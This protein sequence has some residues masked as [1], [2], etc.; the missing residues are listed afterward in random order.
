MTESA[1]MVPK[2]YSAL[3]ILQSELCR[4]GVEKKGYNDKQ[5]FYFRKWDD[6]QQALAP[7]LV[8]SKVLLIPDVVSREVTVG[9][10][11]SGSDY[12]RVMLTGNIRF[13]SVED[14]S[15][16]SFRAV[17]EAADTGDK[18]TSKALT[19]MVKYAVIHG[20]Q[21]PLEGVEDG[22]ESTSVETSDLTYK[23][24]DQKLSSCKTLDALREAWHGLTEHERKII[25]PKRVNELKEKLK[26]EGAAS[27]TA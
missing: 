24:I 22:D 19:M 11:S 9:K 5:K 16:V 10:T 8:H 2:I 21:I 1:L 18:A 17:G 4:V 27:A 20:L 12:F 7:A 3:N 14:G 6:V 23:E 25:G 13:L 15:E 26:T